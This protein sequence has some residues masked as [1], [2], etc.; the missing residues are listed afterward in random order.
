MLVGF[1]VG[2]APGSTAPALLHGPARGPGFRERC[3]AHGGH[4]PADGADHLPW[5]LPGALPHCPD[6]AKPA[7]PWREPGRAGPT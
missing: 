3:E 2:G 4:G 1:G 6:A 5:R 7:G